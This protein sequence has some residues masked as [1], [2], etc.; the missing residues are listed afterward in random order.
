MS[1]ASTKE[2]R[3]NNDMMLQRTTPLILILTMTM[4]STMTFL[5]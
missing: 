5:T 1:I 3:S 4:N 2:Q